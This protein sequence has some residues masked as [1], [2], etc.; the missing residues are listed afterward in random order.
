VKCQRAAE[1]VGGCFANAGGVIIRPTVPRLPN[2]AEFYYVDRVSPF[3]EAPNPKLQT[4]RKHGP[5][6]K[7]GLG[8]S[9]EPGVWDLKFSVKC[10]R[11]AEWVRGCFANAGGVIIRPTVPDLPNLAEFDYV[12]RVN[13][14]AR[15]GSSKSQAPNPRETRAPPL[16]V[17]DLDII[18]SLVFGI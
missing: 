13:R 2:L 4:P 7:F 1:R 18:W 12:D 9:L 8:H 17:W 16:E 15:S 6:L 5:P 14:M 3:R 10:Q 11:A